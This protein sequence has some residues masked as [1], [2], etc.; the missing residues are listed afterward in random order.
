MVQTLMES[1]SIGA[2][3]LASYSTF[4]PITLTVDT[5]YANDN[6]LLEGVE[7]DLGI[8]QGWEAD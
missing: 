5:A 4:D 1:F 8:E 7:A 2:T 3:Y 6:Q